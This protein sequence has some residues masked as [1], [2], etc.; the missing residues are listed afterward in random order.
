MSQ[1]LDSISVGSTVRIA[2]VTGNDATSLRLLEMGLTPG[3]EVQV[4]GTAPLG[5]PIEI[6]VRGYHLSIRRIEASKISVII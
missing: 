3:V 6:E 2:A 5:C 4:L 1:C